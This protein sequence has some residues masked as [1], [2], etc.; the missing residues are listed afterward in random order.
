LTEIGVV[1]SK[2][3]IATSRMQSAGIELGTSCDF[4]GRL[5]QGVAVVS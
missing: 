4:R 1:E 2:S 5:W 3:I